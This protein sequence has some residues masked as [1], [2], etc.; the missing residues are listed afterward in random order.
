MEVG[1]GGGERAKEK[2]RGRE[3]RGWMMILPKKQLRCR[4]GT[5]RR[6]HCKTL[7]QSSPLAFSIASHN[8]FI[9]GG[10][11]KRAR[12]KKVQSTRKEQVS[13]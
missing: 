3:G 2:E 12:E 1:G 6:M 7:V 8:F 5:G 9:R 13:I 11:R 4:L 10:K